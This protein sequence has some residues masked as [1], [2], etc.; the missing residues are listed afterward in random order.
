MDILS[1]LFVYY[2]KGIYIRLSLDLILGIKFLRIRVYKTNYCGNNP[3]V[4]ALYAM[5]KSYPP[6]WPESAATMFLSICSTT[7]WSISIRR[8]VSSTSRTTA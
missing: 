4:A 6:I 7:L 1:G 3:A 5:C 8:V 2:G